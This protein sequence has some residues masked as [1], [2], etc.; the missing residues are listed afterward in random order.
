MPAYIRQRRFIINE[1]LLPIA[2]QQTNASFWRSAIF[3]KRT[4]LL[5]QIEQLQ[6]NFITSNQQRVA[7]LS[8]A[9]IA[10]YAKIDKLMIIRIVIMFSGA[11]HCVVE[12]VDETSYYRY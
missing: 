6:Q 9:A 1:I 12:E 8:R 5:R 3:L 10:K 2:R 7:E 11:A 4:Y